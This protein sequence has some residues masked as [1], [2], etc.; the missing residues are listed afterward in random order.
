VYP[1]ASFTIGRTALINKLLTYVTPK[2]II[3]AASKMSISH[4]SKVTDSLVQRYYD[5]TL[6]EEIGKHLSIG[7]ND[8]CQLPIKDQTIKAT[9]LNFMG[10]E[11]LLIPIEK[12]SQISKRILPIYYVTNYRKLCAYANG[13]KSYRKYKATA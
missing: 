6:R 4:K 13:G 11:D 5:L 2:F 1:I 9:Y 10:R 3:K 8:C 7:S 12:R